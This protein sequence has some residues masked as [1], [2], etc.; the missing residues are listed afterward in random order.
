MTSPSSGKD[1]RNTRVSRVYCC[2]S[3]RL[4]CGSV[5]G[6]YRSVGFAEENG[7]SALRGKGEAH[8]G[9][10]DGVF[11]GDGLVVERF[12]GEAV[13]DRVVED[14]GEGEHCR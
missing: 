5:G 14:G 7:G 12:V 6:E 2:G 13:E 1:Q 8:G 11:D 3:L 4:G 9:V 10:G